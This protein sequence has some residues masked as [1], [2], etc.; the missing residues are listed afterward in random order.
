[1]LDKKIMVNHNLKTL[2]VTTVGVVFSIF[3]FNIAKADDD[4]PWQKSSATI[5][6]GYWCTKWYPITDPAEDASN[7]SFKNEVEP[8]FLTD[9]SATVNKMHY[10]YHGAIP[11]GQDI[12]ESKHRNEG[13]FE[14]GGEEGYQYFVGCRMYQ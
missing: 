14:Q 1:M 6:Y 4:D 2:I 3:F 11:I 8:S 12:P 5:K 13:G 10:K 7:I 9:V